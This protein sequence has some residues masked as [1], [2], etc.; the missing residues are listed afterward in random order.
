MLPGCFLIEKRP[1]RIEVGGYLRRQF[2]HRTDVRA[3][4]VQQSKG[5]VKL[6]DQIGLPGVV[7]TCSRELTSATVR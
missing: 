2:V 7:P 4:F 1:K 5:S 3:S 6:L